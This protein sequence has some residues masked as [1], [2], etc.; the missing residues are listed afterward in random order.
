MQRRAKF[1]FEISIIQRPADS[2]HISAGVSV[3]NLFR[4]FFPLIRGVGDA[5]GCSQANPLI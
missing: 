5:A 1:L 4:L 3:M 2:R